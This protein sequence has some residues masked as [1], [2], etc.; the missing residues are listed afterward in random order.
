MQYK[1][2]YIHNMVS[3]IAEKIEYTSTEATAT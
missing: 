1:K 2:E 3:K